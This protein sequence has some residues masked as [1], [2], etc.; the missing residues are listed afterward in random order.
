MNSSLAKLFGAVVRDLRQEAEMS[1]V[2]FGE[3][4]GFY[5]TYLRRIENGQANPILNAL[6]VIAA[7]LGMTVFEF[8][9]LAHEQKI[10][11]DSVVR[12][13]ANSPRFASP[14]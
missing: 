12:Q 13:V 11:R 4:F 5:Q 14:L 6:E 2:L 7:A 1:Q 3:K 10:R 8:F 9:D